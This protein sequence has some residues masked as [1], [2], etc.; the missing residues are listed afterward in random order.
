MSKP[1]SYR[2]F[3]DLLAPIYATGQRLLPMWRAYTEEALRGLPP[4]GAVLEIGPGP[5]LLLEK[6]AYRETEVT[7]DVIVTLSN[8]EPD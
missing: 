1:F 5:G 3:Y 8:N 2:R 6:T 7:G 4:T